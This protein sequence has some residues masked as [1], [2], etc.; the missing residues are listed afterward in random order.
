MQV[1]YD[2]RADRILWQVRTRAGDLFAVWI[3]RR[4][5]T[6]FWPPFERMVAASGI[7]AQVGMRA[8]F[9]PEAQQMLARA[10]R[11]RPLPQ[12]NFE[13]PFDS[14]P[15][16]APLGADPLLPMQIDLTPI[17]EAP[18]GVSIRI[19]EGDGGRRLDL[20]LGGDLAAALLRLMEK[21]IEASEWG[22]T[23][24]TPAPIPAAAP[25]S[26]N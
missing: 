19:G 13:V 21:A 11:E 9:A 1:R 15:A 24:A 2:A 14:R 4:M 8:T 17:A 22:L 7:A 3:T 25:G 26:L 20:R 10:A 23:T 18:P 16:A 5:A 12:A 6:R